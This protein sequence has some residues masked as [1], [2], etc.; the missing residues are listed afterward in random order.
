MAVEYTDTILSDLAAMVPANLH[1]WNLSAATAIELLNVSENATYALRDPTGR[2]WVL[3]VHRVGYSSPE[4]IRSELAWLNALRR[5][6]VIET[7]APIPG[8]DGEW[9]QRLESRSGAPARFAVAF[10]RLPGK[11]PD[12][13]DALPWFERLGE[14]SA[15][16][17]RH[18]RAWTLPPEFRRKR[19][20][21]DAMV[22]PKGFWGPWRAGMGLDAAGTA[23]LE[24][25]VAAIHRRL[26][27][28]GQGPEVFGLI[29]ADLRLA[30]LL[31]D[32]EHLRIIDFDDCGFG[33]FLYDF[34]TALSFIEH[35][36]SV[37]ALLA[38]WL[39][40]YGRVA[41][42]SAAA[43]AEIPTFVIL[44]RILLTAWL[45]SH[46]ELPLARELGSGYTA[47]TVRLADD[48]LHG[49]FLSAASE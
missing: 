22:G 26:E 27:R 11:E 19:W 6:R 9:V 44:R 48:W 41:A 7:A 37:P 12:A 15:R 2:D 16:M 24:A 39:S 43:V 1:R 23:T 10:E 45:A 33:W 30:N 21:V 25:A 42:L 5:D 36:P 29:H 17:H 3:R 34:A 46:G 8:A 40:G 18:S 13:R 31:V 28:V 47:G 32:G 20:D 4:E 38:A 35:E 49:E 14:L